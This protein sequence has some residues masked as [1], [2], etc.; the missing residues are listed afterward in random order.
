MNTGAMGVAKADAQVKS[1]SVRD[2]YTLFPEYW[3]KKC[4][5]FAN[6]AF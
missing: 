4:L 2:L 3:V 5:G 1:T 6:E